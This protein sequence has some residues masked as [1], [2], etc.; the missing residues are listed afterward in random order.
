ML[1][2]EVNNTIVDEEETLADN[3][4]IYRRKNRIYTLTL[5]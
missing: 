1:V 4:Y 5:D 3:V 2:K